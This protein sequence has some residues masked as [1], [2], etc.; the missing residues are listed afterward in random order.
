MAMELMQVRLSSDLLEKVDSIAKEEG[1]ASRSEVVRE[2]IRML[3][4]EKRLALLERQ[5][6]SI[7]D[8]GES[9][10]QVRE[11]RRKMSDKDFDLDM[12]NRIGRP[13]VSSPRRR[14]P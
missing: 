12:L 7:P 1:Y 9:V 14:L 5:V 2:A 11:I 10:K 13:Q 6:G 8:R 4:T 3:T